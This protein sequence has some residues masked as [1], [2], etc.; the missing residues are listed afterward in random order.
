MPLL[1]ERESIT[2]VQLQ[3]CR[4]VAAAAK[5]DLLVD[6]A[7][8]AAFRHESERVASQIREQNQQIHVSED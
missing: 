5:V 4:A 7:S 6:R 2:I 8:G 3:R 1:S